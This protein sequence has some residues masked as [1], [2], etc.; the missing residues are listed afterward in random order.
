MDGFTTRAIRAASRASRASRADRRPASVPSQQV[1][2]F[3]A[4]GAARTAR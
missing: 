3:A 4:L 1:V 2:T